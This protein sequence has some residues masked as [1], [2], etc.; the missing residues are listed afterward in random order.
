MSFIVFPDILSIMDT[1][2]LKL[3]LTVV[4]IEGSLILHAKIGSP[5][6]TEFPLIPNGLNFDLKNTE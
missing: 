3:L 2:K 6:L 1:V 4:V 5:T